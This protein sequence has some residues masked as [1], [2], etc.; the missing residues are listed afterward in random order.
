MTADMP[1]LW[2][3]HSFNLPVITAAFAFIGV[4]PR[5]KFLAS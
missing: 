1:V 2:A 5:L 4:Y 3:R